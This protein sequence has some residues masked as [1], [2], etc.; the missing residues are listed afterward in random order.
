MAN[1]VRWNIVVSEEVDL[2]LRRHLGVR[3]MRK[4]DLSKFIEEAVRWK[5]LDETV[6]KIKARNKGKSP[7]RIA[8]E[9][10]QAL[11]EVRAKRARKARH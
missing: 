4:G 8:A 1:P 10:E 7:K 11:T 9:V 5:L 2:S 3:G 6:Q